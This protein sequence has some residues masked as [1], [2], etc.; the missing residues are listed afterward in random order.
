MRTLVERIKN[1]TTPATTE[2]TEIVLARTV[3]DNAYEIC[4]KK[5]ASVPVGLMR[6]DHSYQRVLAPNFKKLMNE[7]NNE[8]CDFLMVSYRD[9]YFYVIDG[10]HRYSVAMAKGIVTLPCII[11]NGLTR[12]QEALKFGQQNDGVTRLN[13]YD[14]FKANIACGDVSIKEVYIDMEIKRICDFHKVVVKKVG[15]GQTNPKTL[16]S[17]TRAR[18]IVRLNGAECLDW[19]LAVI[20]VSNWNLCK[21]AYA[22]D[23]MVMLKNFY[24]ENINNLPI[25]QDVLLTSVLNSV[26]P[27]DLIS[28]AKYSYSEYG[29]ETA[30]GLCLKDLTKR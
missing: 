16:R 30:L 28:M 18:N 11:F 26:T 14:V 7:W 9:G 19:I 2:S 20:E 6:L 23:I 15:N 1:A 4:G 17:L 13:P 25:M 12:E 29:L 24:M 21:D 22:A 10:Q 27:T 3:L 8:K 5:V